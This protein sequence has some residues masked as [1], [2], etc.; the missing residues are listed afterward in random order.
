MVVLFC[1]ISYMSVTYNADNITILFVKHLAIADL[2]SLVSVVLPLA[3]VHAARRWVLGCI[4]CYLL[5]ILNSYPGLLHIHFILLISVHR[6]LRCVIPVRSG[7][8]FTRNR[9]YGLVAAVWVYCS[10][11]PV[12]VLLSQ[13]EISFITDSC[14]IDTYSVRSPGIGT[15]MATLWVL[16]ICVPFVLVILAILFLAVNSCKLTGVVWNRNKRILYTTFL[17]GG[18]FVFSWSPHIIF[19]FWRSINHNL[20]GSSLN[21]IPQYCHMVSLCINPIVYT[22]VNRNFKRFMKEHARKVSEATTSFSTGGTTT[23]SSRPSLAIGTKMRRW[24]NFEIIFEN[25]TPDQECA[26]SSQRRSTSPRYSV[27]SEV[28]TIRPK[29]KTRRISRVALPMSLD[30]T[31]KK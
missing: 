9:S 12:C 27:A 5:G 13:L 11:I 31:T 8:F 4:G 7:S 19:T 15:L 22:I 21:R 10:V 26:Q 16:Y 6:L 28:L 24:T 29:E 30:L 20:I 17:I 23:T 1:S 14:T 18:L 3:V 2:L 25:S